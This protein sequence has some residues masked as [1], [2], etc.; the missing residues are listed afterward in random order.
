[1]SDYL[2]VNIDP[3]ASRCVEFDWNIEGYLKRY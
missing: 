3:V 1:V 2:K